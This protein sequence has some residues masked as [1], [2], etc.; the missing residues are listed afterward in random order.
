MHVQDV[1]IHQYDVIRVFRLQLHFKSEKDLLRFILTSL[2]L[3]VQRT[4][5][6]GGF[7]RRFQYCTN[8][9]ASNKVTVKRSIYPLLYSKYWGETAVLKWSTV[10]DLIYDSIKR[11]FKVHEK[12]FHYCIK[13][14]SKIDCIVTSKKPGVLIHGA[15]CI[16]TCCGVQ[17]LGTGRRLTV[18]ALK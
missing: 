15:L 1:Y 10:E 6:F 11:D 2:I 5:T 8:R 17:I 14:I 12:A 13:P 7:P 9:R 4:S 16:K 3:S 18:S